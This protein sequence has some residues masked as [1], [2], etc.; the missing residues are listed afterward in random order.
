M[1][2]Q[3]P[4][5][6]G[7]VDG[8]LERLAALAEGSGGPAGDGPS[9]PS[10]VG[11]VR[12]RS[13]LRGEEIAPTRT[14]L[15]ASSEV[16]D[17][18][19]NGGFF[20]QAPRSLADA[21][22]SESEVEAIILRLLLHCGKA[23]GLEIAQQ[24]ALPFP[25]VQPLLAAFK[26]RQWL[27]LKGSTSLN[28]YVYEITDAGLQRARRHAEQCSY[29]G[30]VPVALSDYRAGVAAQSLQK[31]S[32]R[33]EDL[34]RAFADL[35][36]GAK[37]FARLGRAI[38]SGRG[39][40]LYG[41][42]GNGKTSIAERITAAYGSSIWIPRAISAWGEI[43][44]LFDPSCH[45]E[46]RPAASE[47]ILQAEKGD[48]RWVRIRRPTIVVGG[49]LTMDSLEIIVHKDTGVSE[50]PIQMKSN[51][52]TLVIDDFGRQRVLPATLLNRW[53]VP[54][55]KR[56]DYLCL[57]SG[58]KI[59]VPFDQ[60]IVFATNLEPKDLV[61]EA[62]LRRI[63]YK[64]DVDNPTMEEFR[65]LFSRSCQTLGI[66]YRREVLD[67]LIAAH[68]EAT[69]R[70]MRFCHARDLLHQVAIY[71]KFHE[72]PAEMSIEAI[73]AAAEDYFSML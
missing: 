32:P 4:T 10:S 5:A 58:R 25:V 21:H 55:E 42:P 39:L 49:E 6:P 27:A 36:L 37:M 38:T 69:G 44:R 19:N 16:P 29:F 66:A 46:M 24:I 1:I 50:A 26:T 34:H 68:Y 3:Q 60:F 63:P 51:C 45:E 67:H 14:E 73:D 72:R 2:D 13:P 7:D 48:L 40:F 47:R 62:F 11:T 43:V 53:I 35:T 61:D 28:D 8:F 33:I 64:I 30:A 22:I 31:T 23:T 41:R 57:A 20:P 70:Q 17:S 71:C 52:G 12:L 18:E 54:L 56:H 15:A 65:Q 59:R 9:A